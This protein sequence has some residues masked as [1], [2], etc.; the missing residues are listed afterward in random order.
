MPQP[1]RTTM[2]TSLGPFWWAPL[3]GGRVYS[4]SLAIT[5]RWQ[6]PGVESKVEWCQADCSPTALPT[7]KGHVDPNSRP[8][9]SAPNSRF[10][11]RDALH[12]G[13][14]DRR[15]QTHQYSVYLH[16]CQKPVG[17]CRRHECGEGQ[18]LCCATQQQRHFCGWW[19]I[20][21]WRQSVLF[22][23]DRTPAVVTA[24]MDQMY[25]AWCV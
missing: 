4:V 10:M 5:R 1:P 11:W 25:L 2:A 22:L 23:V 19:Q 12:S 8:S 17:L 6:L 16:P 18:P 3:P 9:H 15:W 20:S 13:W 14:G 7:T 21:K 24:Q